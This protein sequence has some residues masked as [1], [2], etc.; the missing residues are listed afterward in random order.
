MDSRNGS[1]A[2]L[3]TPDSE[4]KSFFDSALPLKDS[5]EITRK[6]KEFIEL[7]SSSTG[8]R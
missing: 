1:E 2:P 3:E 6:L 5:A 4:V 7:H 8:K